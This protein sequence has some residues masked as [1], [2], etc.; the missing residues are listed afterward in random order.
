[1]SALSHEMLKRRI[2]VVIVGYHAT[3]L[4]QSRYVLKYEICLTIVSDS[5]FQ[6]HIQKT[7]WIVYSVHAMKLAIFFNSSSHPELRGTQSHPRIPTRTMPS[8]IPKHYM[9]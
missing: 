2:A 8:L 5:V 4:V 6:Q 1:M 9:K 3:P 7:I